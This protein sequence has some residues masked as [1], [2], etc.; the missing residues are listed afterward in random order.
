MLKV[1]ENTVNLVEFA[2]GVLMLYGNL[3]AVRLTYCMILVCPGVPDV[4]RELS[5]VV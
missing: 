3:I 1:V 2:L 5:Y 4:G